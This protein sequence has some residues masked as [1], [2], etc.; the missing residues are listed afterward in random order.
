[1]VG[2]VRRVALAGVV[3]AVLS[4]PVVAQQ[5]SVEETI[6]GYYQ[7]VGGLDRIR[8]VMSR[9][10]T[11]HVT[12][13]DGTEATVTLLLKRPMKMRSEFTM[14]GA[15]NIQAFDGEQAWML[16]PMMGQT[17]PM[18]LPAEIAEAVRG[19][20][21]FDGPLVDYG[22]KGHH[23]RALGTETV[24]GVEAVTLE[25]TLQNGA[26]TIY[27]LDAGSLL[28]IKTASDRTVQG[29]PMHVETRLG[30]YR[31]V[32]GLMV[33]FSIRILQGGETQTLTIGTIE[34]NIEIDDALF[35]M[36][37]SGGS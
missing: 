33:P 23:I 3:A 5:P 7:A 22:H 30:D 10:M 12:G 24:E 27:Y 2:L 18:Q 15:T 8:S 25:I 6:S 19:E 4:P 32:D 1:M 29:M 35:R 13:T 37:R 36:P 34:H 17:E 21:D 20:A 31:E 14:E 11:G 28:P 26:V 9:K 16:A